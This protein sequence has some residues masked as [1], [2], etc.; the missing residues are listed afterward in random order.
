MVVL[1]DLKYKRVLLKVSGEALMGVKGFGIDVGVVDRIAFDIAKMQAR[2]VSIAIVIGGGNIARGVALAANKQERVTGDHMGMLAT[3]IN[4]LALRSALMRLNVEG[5]ILS[6]ISMPQICEAFSQQRVLKNLDAG[7]IV[8][9]AA[10]TGNPFFTTDTA[11]A[12]RAA[13]IGAD[14]LIKATQVDGV[15]DSDPR[16][17]ANAKKLD[18]VS[19]DDVL[20]EN[21]SIMDMTAISLAKD[22][23]IPIIIYSIIE[24]NGLE[25]I[26]YGRGNFSVIS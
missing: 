3:A 24:A 11:A 4:A 13:E 19:Y 2:G 5:V 26:L 14:V 23:A 16:I 18:T 8:I 7:K 12:L 10:G 25:K 21:F 6:A 22:N 17:N 1:E 15:Y 9:F 20:K